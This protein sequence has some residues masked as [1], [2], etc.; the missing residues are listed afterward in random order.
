MNMTTQTVITERQE[1]IQIIDTLSDDAI[2]KLAPYVAFLRYEDSTPN[3]ETIEAIEECRA[4]KGKRA[5]SV[6]ELLE[7][8]NNDEGN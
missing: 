1:I 3:A 4:R 5:S 2:G 6:N 7:R 8:L